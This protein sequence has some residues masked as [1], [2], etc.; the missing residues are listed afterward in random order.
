MISGGCGGELTATGD[1]QT[2]SSEGYGTAG[3]YPTDLTCVWKITVSRPNDSYIHLL[4][5]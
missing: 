4:Y 1:K 2:I 3:G 5:L